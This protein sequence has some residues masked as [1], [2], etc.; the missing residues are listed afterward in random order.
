MPVLMLLWGI[1]ENTLDHRSRS[2]LGMWLSQAEVF[3]G[4][5]TVWTWGTACTTQEGRGCPPALSG[6]GRA[7]HSARTV[8]RWE[9]HAG[10][11][12]GLCGPYLHL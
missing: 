7:G 4:V 12:R 8:G 2:R 9:T 10:R 5:E 6:A 3:V 1:G 11:G